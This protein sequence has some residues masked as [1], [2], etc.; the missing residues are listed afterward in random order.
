MKWLM[1][2]ALAVFTLGCKH[3]PISPS[4]C[5]ILVQASE[6][7]AVRIAVTSG[8]KKDDLVEERASIVA[9]ALVLGCVFIPADDAD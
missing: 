6:R 8:A 5:A 9:D 1:V 2:L 3:N 7:L 4:D